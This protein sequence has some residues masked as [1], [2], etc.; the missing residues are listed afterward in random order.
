MLDDYNGIAQIAQSLQ[1]TDKPMRISLMQ[2][3]TRLVQHVERTHQAAAELRS[4][5]DALALSTR[6]RIGQA[7]KC[8]IPQPHFEQEA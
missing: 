1:N 8:Q 5:T 7:V 3:D 2:T 4:Q 6:E